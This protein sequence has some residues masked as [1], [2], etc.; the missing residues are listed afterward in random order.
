MENLFL[1]FNLTVR[2]LDAGYNKQP[3]FNHFVKD[4]DSHRL[5]DYEKDS[6]NDSDEIIIAPMYQQALDFIEE[7]MDCC[8]M[9]FFNPAN[10]KW[11][12][13]V[14]ALKANSTLHPIDDKDEDN[15]P[16]GL[17]TCES[18]YAAYDKV[19]SIMIDVINYYKSSDYQ[20]V[21]DTKETNIENEAVNEG[22]NEGVKIQD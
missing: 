16:M 18:K 20:I 8:I 17:G 10:D 2:I 19:I 5:F 15:P 12:F 9:T 3:F 14:F 7:T 13:R 6:L 11:G 21:S 22:V 1:P 4:G